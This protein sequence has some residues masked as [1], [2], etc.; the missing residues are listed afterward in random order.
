M[1]SQPASKVSLYVIASIGSLL[2]R[3]ARLGE[4]FVAL[5]VSMYSDV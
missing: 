2:T 4:L 1:L 3:H 5:N